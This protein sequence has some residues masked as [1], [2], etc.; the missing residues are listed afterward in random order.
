M[1]TQQLK[2]IKFKTR[3]ETGKIYFTVSDLPL[4]F[5]EWP[6]GPLIELLHGELYLMPSPSLLHQEISD[7]LIFQIKSYLKKNPVGKTFSAPIDVVLSEENVVIPDIV[8][9]SNERSH[10][11]KEKRIEGT[12]DFII[13]ITSSNKRHDYI[14]KKELYE[15]FSVQEY[16]IVDPDDKIVLTYLLGKNGK[17][18]E[19]C[20]YQIPAK[21]PVKI[22]TG[23]V[24]EIELNK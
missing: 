9:V 11:L 22:L 1:S 23:L 7:E 20:E 8:F 12:P 24:L 17:Y 18:E 5:P 19:P 10:I 21:I 14:E 3:P 6:E 4:L 13:E 15:R 16:W 2:K